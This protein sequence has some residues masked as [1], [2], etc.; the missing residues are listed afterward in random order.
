MLVIAT[1]STGD[2]HSL[3]PWVTFVPLTEKQDKAV[4]CMEQPAKGGL[5]GKVKKV[6]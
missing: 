2:L 5:L 4:Y 6:S 1:M 3:L